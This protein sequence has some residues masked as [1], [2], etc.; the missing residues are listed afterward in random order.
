MIK[1]IQY[2][3]LIKEFNKS[4]EIKMSSMKSGMDRKT[5]K[6]Y[7]ELGKGPN[8]VKQPHTWR[9]RKD[10]FADVADEINDM[11][12]NAEE[13]APITIFDYL[14]DKYPGRFMDGQ[15]RTLERRVKEWR[16]HK[17]KSQIV[18]IPQNHLP[19]Q[20]MELDWTS[21]NSLMIT[22]CGVLFKH[23]LCH[24]VLTYSNWEWAEIAYSE[25]FQSLKKGFQ[26]AVYRLGAVP[27]V[28]QT[29]NSSTATHQVEKGKKTRDFNQNYK[30][31]LD[32][33]GVTPRTINVNS[34]DENGDI[35]SANGHL[36]R[37]IEQYLR[38][39]GSRDFES[40]DEYRSFLNN[41]LIKGNRNRA[42]KVKEELQVMRELPEI[43]LPEYLEEDKTVS[44][45]GTIRVKKVTYSVPTRLK[46]YKVR[47]RVYEDRIEVFSGRN[48]IHTLPRK[49]GEG[50][51]INYR[52]VIES[53]RRKP[54]AF[55]NCRYKDQLFPNE[56]FYRVYERLKE[57]FN[58]RLA[59]KEY[60]EIVSLAAGHG[61]DKVSGILQ[62]LLSC[63]K[64]LT[65]DA[66]KHK[67][68]LPVSIPKVN[69]PAPVLSTY[70]EFLTLKQGG[71]HAC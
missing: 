67:L 48:H 11:L 61:E 52:H 26:S 49:T 29:D 4:G 71:L 33:F 64:L 44:S 50:Y 40:I 55:A 57:Q 10:P 8:E 25:S 66:V 53:L 34:P 18:S 1:E 63:E 70:N 20:L 62:E 59:D 6:K 37:R 31:F 27:C 30:S 23:L 15:L 42:S 13:L 9:T 58:E 16:M 43:S 3:T 19:G 36:K 45:F 46:G 2:R 41:V 5:G 54:G 21:M 24:T 65:M 7:L 56:V 51:S 47:V 69:R 39:R 17:G 60:I 22:I 14:Q 12:E 68:E 28:L 35:E 32:H 38:L